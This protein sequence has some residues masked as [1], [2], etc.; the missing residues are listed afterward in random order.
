MGAAGLSP[1]LGHH[2]HT[3]PPS[4]TS[5]SH[6]PPRTSTHARS[7]WVHKA[8]HTHGHNGVH[9]R[10]DRLQGPDGVTKSILLSV[11]VQTSTQVQ[12]SLSLQL[13]AKNR[14]SRSLGSDQN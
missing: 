13:C 2:R 3:H 8:P 4:D 12:D 7:Q 10:G 6:R 9:K 5:T 11:W 1:P 14:P